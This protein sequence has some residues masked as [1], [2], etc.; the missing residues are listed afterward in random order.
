MIYKVSTGFVCEQTTKIVTARA[1]DRFIIH[2]SA[3]IK[4]TIKFLLKI[5]EGSNIIYKKHA[6]YRRRKFLLDA[7]KVS[8]SG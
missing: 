2:C 5:T 4:E 3:K 7:R 8:I 6:L 1:Y